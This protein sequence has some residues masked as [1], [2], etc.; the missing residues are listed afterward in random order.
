METPS[1]PT[2]ADYLNR[3]R[4]A[5]KAYA[6]LRRINDLPALREVDRAALIAA[7]ELV[8]SVDGDVIE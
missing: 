5:R 8:P 1:A 4:L 2:Q 3:A 6:L 7:I